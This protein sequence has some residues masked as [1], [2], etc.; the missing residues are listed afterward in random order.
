ML[1]PMR[2]FSRLT[3]FILSLAAIL[4][5]Q[6]LG[7]PSMLAQSQRPQQPQQLQQPQQGECQTFPETGKTVCGKFLSYWQGHGGVDQLG[8][9]ISGEFQEQSDIDSRVYTVQYFERAVLELHPENAA[10]NDVLLSLLGSLAYKQKYPNGAP[11]LPAPANPVAGIF[12]PQTGKEIRGEFLTYW[13]E[14]GGLQQQ[15]YPITNLIV[16]KSDLD[17]KQ[18]T[19]QYFERAVFESHPEKAPPYNVLLSQLGTLRFAQ[20]YPYPPYGHAQDYSWL[21]GQLKQQG[22]C[23]VVTYVSPLVDILAD[24]YSNNVA[25]LPGPGWQSTGLKDGAWVVVQGQVEPGTAPAA[26]CTAHGYVVSALQPNPNAADAGQGTAGGESHLLTNDNNNSS[27]TLHVGDTLLLEL[28]D[29]QWSTPKLDNAIL[30]VAPL[31]I[32]VPQGVT[33]WKYNALTPGQT[34][35]T[36]D[37]ACLPNPGGPSCMSI[38]V[39]KVTITVV[40]AE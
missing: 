17:G 5:F 9:P 37:G 14:H 18:Y 28:R 24:Q 36:S 35:L 32:T 6:T 1:R 27:I 23:W 7:E 12:F 22:S 8:F 15:G 29:R 3:V 11:E 13:K 21:A 31:N 39:Y 20:K 4:I 40:G 2:L 16:E 25:L 34:E 10:P 19:V 26:G 38:L 30:G 33:A